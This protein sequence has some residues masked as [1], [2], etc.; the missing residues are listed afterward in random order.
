MVSYSRTYPQSFVGN[1]CHFACFAHKETTIVSIVSL[2]FG[3][4]IFKYFTLAVNSVFCT[5]STLITDSYMLVLETPKLIALLQF[6]HQA[7]LSGMIMLS[8]VLLKF[9]YILVM[10]VVVV[11]K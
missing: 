6:Q 9:A 5:Y 1:L 7:N 3:S 11:F 10:M 4:C 8:F 2:S